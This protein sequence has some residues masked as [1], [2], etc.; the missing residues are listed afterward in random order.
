MSRIQINDLN[1]HSEGLR[2]LSDQELLLIQGGGWLGD[3]FS[4]LDDFVHD[5]LGGWLKVIYTVA[6]WYLGS[7]G[8][9]GGGGG[10]SRGNN[11]TMNLE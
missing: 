1:Y 9:G 6:S 10:G 5:K 7:G 8:G 3:F 2:D 11:A 4:S